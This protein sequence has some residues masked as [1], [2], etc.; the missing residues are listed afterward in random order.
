MRIRDGQRLFSA[1]DLV[2]FLGC[3]HATTLDL[4]QLEDPVALADDDPQLVLLRAKGME[5]ERAYLAQ[6]R[7]RGLNVVE[8]GRGDLAEQLAQTREAMAAGADV[9]YQGALWEPPWH[10]FSDFLIRVDGEASD[11]GDYA[12]DI[13]D[14]KL[15]RAATP[16]HV[17]QLGVYADLV[18]GLQGRLQ[19]FLRVVIGDGA[20]T[21][22]LS[23]DVMDYCAMARARFE[24][25]VQ[26]RPTTSS[27]PCAH[28]DVCRWRDRC[29]QEWE[30]SEHLV[31]VAGISRSQ[32]DKLAA[33]GID[34]MRALAGAD[35]SVRVPKLQPDTFAK[36]RAQAALQI[37]RR[38]GGEPSYE[39][40]PVEPLRGFNRLPHA[41]P[42]DLFFDMEGDP[43]F[44]GG[45]EYLFGFV[46]D[47]DDPKFTT[48]WGH[49]RAQEKQA[50]EAAVDFIMARL[51][52]HPGAHVYHYAAYEET[53]L[54]RLAMLH[55]TREAEVD[56][57]L[58][59]RKLVDLYKVVREGVRTS[60][61]GLSIKKLEAFYLPEARSGEVTTAGDSIVMYERWRELGG[62]ERLQEIADY[63]ELDCR[64]T[65]LCR[66]WLLGLRPVA[67]T[68]FSAQAATEADAENTRK[69]E[70]A[71]ERTKG[72]VEALTHRAPECERPWRELLAYL[73][74]FHR[75]E[76][77]PEYW[78][79][80]DRQ[81]LTEE[82]LTDD[83]ECIGGL[84]IDPRRPK[85]DEKRSAVY[86]FTF[87]PQDFKMK[88]GDRPIRA[89]TL[90]PVGEIVALDAD[91]GA[92]SLKVGPKTERP[93]DGHSLIPKGPYNYG[94]L[95]DALVS[96]ADA[97]MTGTAND[98]S[99]V[100]DIL[101]RSAP[102]LLGRAPGTPIVTDGDDQLVGAIQAVSALDASYLPI[103][104]PPGAGKSFTS[105]EAI[106]ALLKAGKRVGVASHSHKAINTLLSAVEAAAERR[107]A[108][109][110]G[111]K[112]SSDEDE[113]LA[114]GRCIEDTTDNAVACDGSYDLV[115]GTA[116]LFA[117]EEMKSTLDYLFIDE[118][119]Q[120]SLA[121][122]VAMGLA[123]KNIVLVGDQMQ[124]SQ[125][126][127]G[128]HPGG[129]G[130]AALDHLLGDA[131]TVP[132]DRGIFL[133]I[134]RRMHP[135]ICGFISDAIYEGRL[136]SH[137]DTARQ[138]L[139]ILPDDPPAIV[140]AGLRFVEV[141]H[142]GCTQRCEQEAAQLAD[143]YR[144]LLGRTW[145]NE[146]GEEREIGLDNI[147]VVAPYNM[148]TN[149]LR[150][151]LPEG[152]RVGTVDKFR[153]HEAAVVLISMTTSSAED[154]PRQMEFLYS[155]N[156]LNVAISRARALAVIFASPR[157]LEAPCRTIEQMRLVNTLCWARRYSER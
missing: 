149:L 66:D 42:G 147:L 152:A 16:K 25:F 32:R 151:R 60:E 84:R 110:R 89:D 85:Y 64:S 112:K 86:S 141:E 70:E 94:V 121:N 118:A 144:R 136:T 97:V 73:L 6:L 74:E 80:F 48:F 47:P 113:K 24:A 77:K 119:G 76:A 26:D 107:R 111:I 134:T 117:R 114:S 102:R 103:Q 88:V 101:T 2:N 4:R 3:P 68:W 35:A 150:E 109:F 50:F 145:I 106:V 130:V 61:P 8:I 72:L 71:A 44:D 79:M 93:E 82:E 67:A 124:L 120:V 39:T 87:P 7:G 1:S 125:P 28:C 55:G 62:D 105:A 29:K 104:G 27:E 75:R 108:R 40:L 41:D 91:E 155:R 139:A 10:G 43:L 69:R 45:L 36:L 133:P 9:I 92:I 157:L 49:D 12:Y 132:A 148:Q 57:L 127:K 13:A 53:A 153:G 38:D 115:A 126:M 5:H 63:N 154:L 78:A 81:T 137:E 129:S 131:R 46:S 143:V 31:L 11:F 21:A 19:P 123:A 128:V 58:R 146:K 83:P 54:K 95:R 138:R 156:R 30:T 122:T 22:V 18:G 37:A 33:A 56:E 100:L 51:R 20:E 17:L 96:L 98:Y 14:T 135:A 52:T 34:S 65:L 142:V 99:A 59:G 23:T 116:W 15:A 140:E 90:L